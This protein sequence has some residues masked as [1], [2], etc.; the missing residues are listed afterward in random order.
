MQLSQNALPCT[1]ISGV[2]GDTEVGPIL[3]CFVLH[4]TMKFIVKLQIFFHGVLN[5]DI[6]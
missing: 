1:R 4:G 6:R 2:H 5:L 3:R